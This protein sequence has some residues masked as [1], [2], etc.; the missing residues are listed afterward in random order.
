VELASITRED[1]VAALLLY[2][3]RPDPRYTA[4]P[5]QAPRER[6]NESMTRRVSAIRRGRGR[7]LT[8]STSTRHSH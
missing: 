6:S 3:E 1:L 5:V 4:N 8:V 7:G 2:R